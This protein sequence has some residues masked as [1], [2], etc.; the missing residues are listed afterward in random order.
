MCAKTKRIY[1]G[2][3]S[4]LDRHLVKFRRSR[5][6]N[7]NFSIICNNCWAGYVYRRYGLPYLTPTVGLY[8][9]PDEFLKLCSDLKGYMSKEPVFIPYTD[10]KYRE[11]IEK[12][13]QTT[14]PIARLGDIEIVFL[15][16]KTEE[17]AKEKWL[18]RAERINYDNLIFKFS[19]MNSCTE[20][21]LRQFDQF[22]FSKK[23]C[24]IPGKSTSNIKCG[25]R[26]KSAVGKEIYNDTDEY[27]RY[28]NITKMINAKTVCGNSMEGIW[29]EHDEK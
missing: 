25:I 21:Q 9:F 4:I 23:L 12:K 17:E 10:S 2:I 22:D 18:R 15:H 28:V 11:A 14:V 16:Y 27:S 29:N 20:E 3:S 6:N 8:L 26:F 24:F 7:T 19:K 13:Q 1:R 5:L